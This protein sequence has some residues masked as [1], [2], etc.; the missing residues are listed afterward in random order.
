MAR[1]PALKGEALRQ[2]LCNYGV[3]AAFCNAVSATFPP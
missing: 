2:F 3:G 1:I